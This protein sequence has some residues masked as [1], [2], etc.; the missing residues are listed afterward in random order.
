MGH[1]SQLEP[2]PPLQKRNSH[3]YSPGKQNHSHQDLS[4]PGS[5]LTLSLPAPQT[6]LGSLQFPHLFLRPLLSLA[7]AEG[8]GEWIGTS[9]GVH[10]P[11]PLPMRGPLLGGGRSNLTRA[12]EVSVALKNTPSSDAADLSEVDTARNGE[13][14]R[15]FY[16]LPQ[17][18]RTSFATSHL[19]T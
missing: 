8:L 5:S 2:F 7:L 15:H 16:S 10:T 1:Y 4:T 3:N 17:T 19:E 13:H 9:L 6:A 12:P 11:Q 14:P 18:R